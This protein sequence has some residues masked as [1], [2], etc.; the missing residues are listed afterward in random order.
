[1]SVNWK[2]SALSI[3]ALA[4]LNGVAANA[5][6]DA[7]RT[8]KLQIGIGPAAP[9]NLEE[10]FLNMAQMRD[11]DWSFETGPRQRVDGQTA[12]NQGFLDPETRMPTAKA[13]AAKFAENASFYSGAEN[14][15]GYY[16]D[17]YVLSWT[18]DARG[19]MQRWEG[20]AP[21]TREKNR[22]VYSLSAPQV[23]GGVLRFGSINSS[24]SDIKLYR[25]RYES[26]VERGEIWNP[27]FISYVK[28][29]DIARTMD[30]QYSNNLP[31][32]RFDQ[33]ATMSQAWGQRAAM[34]WPEPP[35]Y[36]IPYEVLFDLGVKAGVEVWLTV[37]LQIGSPISQ[38]DPALRWEHKPS[39]LNANKF[40][41]AVA[42]R[43]KEILASAEWDIFA[44]EFVQR[45]AASGYP[46][47]RPLYIE[48]GNE[49]WNNAGGFFIS[50]N[51]AL[52][53]AEGTG[54]KKNVG[55]GYGVLA[56]RYVIA[57]EKEFAR[58]KIHP[59]VIYVIGTHTANPWRTQQALEGFKQYMKA[60]G[61]NPDS[62]LSKT[63]VAVTNYYGHFN[64]MSLNLF[65]TKKPSEY[66]P[67][68]IAEIKKDPEGFRRRISA[69]LTDGPKS[70]KAT[71]PWL[72]DRFAE[73]KAIAEGAGSRLI[74][75]YEGGSHL[76]PPGELARDPVFQKWWKDYHW[77]AEGAAVARRINQDIIKA[78]PGFII[79][80]Y[81]SIGT[82]SPTS[83]WNDGHYAD[84]TPMMKMWDEF[85]RP[86]AAK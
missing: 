72:L 50:T 29:Y 16:A 65:G 22:V 76:L 71:G 13:G 5:A 14:F 24:V 49:V 2:A 74:G 44:R 25:R 32:R 77:S 11:A 45:Y 73:H 70:L 46:M 21:S 4:V 37:P 7:P 55:Q 35:F 79:S 67:K 36:S 31:V 20:A 33:I 54:V 17:E 39:R 53:I 68:W 1:M 12:V 34:S 48:P 82:L 10:P 51:Y 38:A 41:A 52:A 19:Y 47:S 28:R 86:D 40:R 56:A 78:Y 83:P 62:V 58:R 69:L 15:R 81:K 6:G 61:V 30:L 8:Y 42:P 26:L 9:Y 57:L 84:V 75:G 60:S 80:N 23:K 66:A 27:E 3:S 43:A 63:G 18:G 85:A 64:D 59:N